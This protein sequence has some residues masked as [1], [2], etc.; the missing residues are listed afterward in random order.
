MEIIIFFPIAFTCL[1]LLDKS[2]VMER[3]W[4]MTGSKIREYHDTVGP[5]P[6]VR[7]E[8]EKSEG[9]ESDK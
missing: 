2:E 9:Q 1:L 5:L 7:D 3:L 4:A 8:W 6:K